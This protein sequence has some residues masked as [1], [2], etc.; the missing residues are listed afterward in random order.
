MIP[1]IYIHSIVRGS[2]STANLSRDSLGW[3]CI[4][5]LPAV[6]VIGRHRNVEK[7]VKDAYAWLAEKYQEGDRIY[8][9]GASRFTA[10][11]SR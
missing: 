5:P 11:S 1:T 10:G 8:L 2:G 3:F 7:N 6:H 9:F 4:I